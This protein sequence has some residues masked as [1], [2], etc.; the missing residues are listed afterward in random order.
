MNFAQ[1][2]WPF[3]NTY[4]TSLNSY[5]SAQEEALTPTCIYS[6]T[7][8]NQVAQAVAALSKG[9]C[10]FAVRSGGH[11]PNAGAANIDTDVTIDLSGLNQISLSSDNTLASVS[12]GQRWGA[13][14]TQLAQYGVAIAGG[15]GSSIGVGGLTLGGT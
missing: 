8:A 12:P 3:N 5:W 7:N 10:Q 14:Y 6:P 9:G 1:V 2:S 13:V 4:K 11:T 15:R